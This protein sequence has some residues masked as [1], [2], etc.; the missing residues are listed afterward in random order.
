M[1]TSIRQFVFEAIR[2]TWRI[3]ILNPS[4][5]FA[6]EILNE[7]KERIDILIKSIPAFAV[8]LSSQESLKS[9][10]IQVS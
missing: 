5:L 9:R 2:H 10:N 3:D 1:S 7:V 4:T 8:T 6:D